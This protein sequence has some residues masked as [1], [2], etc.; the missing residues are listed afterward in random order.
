MKT[1]KCCANCKHI[2]FETA[3][4]VCFATCTVLE[5]EIPDQDIEGF[6]CSRFAAKKEDNV[7]LEN[8]YLSKE[9][10]DKIF[11]DMHDMNEYRFYQGINKAIRLYLKNLANKNKK[12]YDESKEEFKFFKKIFDGETINTELFDEISELPYVIV[13][14]NGTSSMQNGR[15]YSAYLVR[16]SYKKS[17]DREPAE[18]EIED[19]FDFYYVKGE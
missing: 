3:E 19:E 4:G 2:V 18:N 15:W 7:K 14:D 1:N 11:N 16:S 12:L 17:F 9:E 8:E 13:W 5:D 6:Y 10:T